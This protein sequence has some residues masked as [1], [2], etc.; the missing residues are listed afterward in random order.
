MSWQ[1]VEIFYQL[2]YLQILLTPLE[3]RKHSVVGL[4]ASGGHC[5]LPWLG[6][7]DVLI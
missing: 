7:K 4:V 5:L 3:R 1:F 6:S 2:P